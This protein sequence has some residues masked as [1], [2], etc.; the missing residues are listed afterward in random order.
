MGGGGT[1]GQPGCSLRVGQWAGFS[2]QRGRRDSPQRWGDGPS[3][4]QAGPS[5][6]RP[7]ATSLP[8][9][10]PSAVQGLPVA[11]LSSPAGPCGPA[12]GPEP[13]P[14]SP[15]PLQQGLPLQWAGGPGTC[16]SRVLSLQLS[17]RPFPSF[18]V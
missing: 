10:L 11:T 9:P 17:S 13:R 18:P 15:T 1:A 4:S 14:L 7:S 8:C 12:Y 6:R 16:P 3:P 2:A 5:G